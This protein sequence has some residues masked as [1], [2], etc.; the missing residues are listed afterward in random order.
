MDPAFARSWWADVLPNYAPVPPFA[1]ADAEQHEL[2]ALD[3]MAVDDSYV[4]PD[5]ALVA[6]ALKSVCSISLPVRAYRAL[7]ADKAV[8]DLKEWVPASFVGPN[9]LKVLTRRSD[10]TLRSG[11]PGAFTYD[12]F[13]NVILDRV[14]EVAAQAALD[15]TVFEG[16]CE[17]N[18]QTSVPAL[19]RDILKLY[20]EDF[21]ARW[22]SLLHDI[23]LAPLTN[24]NVASENLKDLSSRDSALKRLLTAVV[25]ETDLTRTRG[26]VGGRQ[27]DG[28]QA[29]LEAV[30]QARQAREAR[31]DG[32]E[33]HAA[34]RWRQR[35]RPD[36]CE[37]RRTFQAAQGNDRGG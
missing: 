17:E 20:Y 34:W 23:R 11:L 3:R 29:D 12:G 32:S 15:R 21:V 13:H 24:L 9:G 1:S 18:S 30:R 26:C 36:R 14:D 6:E 10:K 8:K 33:A 16:G 5:R 37:R 19:S 31:Q 27:G 7:L 4:E 28:H 22:D 2:A 35:H 25:H